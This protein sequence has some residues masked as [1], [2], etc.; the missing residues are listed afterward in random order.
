M[1]KKGKVKTNSRHKKSKEIESLSKQEIKDLKRNLLA[2]TD[3][4]NEKSIK[5]VKKKEKEKQKLIKKQKNKEKVIKKQI[6]EIKGEKIIEN[7]QMK[8]YKVKK[9]NKAN[10]SNQDNK[11]H[12][13][14]ELENGAI[15]QKNNKIG[16]EKI[17]YKSESNNQTLLQLLK[18]KENIGEV[19]L[20]E[21]NYESRKKNNLKKGQ[22]KLSMDNKSEEEK[23]KNQT[24]DKYEYIKNLKSKIV[25]VN[26]KMV[27]E[28]PDVGLINKK[29]NEE[30]YKNISPMKTIFVN[31]EEKP[32]NSLSFLDIKP[33]KKWTEEENKLFYKA[34]ELFGLDFS[35][36]EI[37]LKKRS[38]DEIKRK[39][40]KEKKENFN[41]I[42]KAI[43]LRK[44]NEKLNQILELYKNEKGQNYLGLFKEESFR[45]RRNNKSKDEKID[46][47]KEYKNILNEK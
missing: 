13:I 4:K 33:T 47:E 25:M 15:T 38:R 42:E 46:Y 32:V 7:K 18:N 26:G 6:K 12:K 35:M 40:N 11:N 9:E 14:K 2:I 28:K 37:V 41:E 43:N 20:N 24:D 8:E 27:M 16:K 19:S 21:E 3:N 30:H 45:N 31:N 22:T 1:A 36:I 23:H 5:S 39:F 17:L 10:N 29:Y 44:N 34:I